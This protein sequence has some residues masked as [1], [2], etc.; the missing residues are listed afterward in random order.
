[1][2]GALAP[3]S[4]STPA[5]RAAVGDREHTRCLGRFSARAGAALAVV[6]ELALVA[7]VAHNAAGGIDLHV[8]R[9]HAAGQFLAAAARHLLVSA[10]HVKRP[11][12]V[13]GERSA[14][15]GGSEA[16]GIHTA[17]LLDESGLV[18]GLESPEGRSGPEGRSASKRRHCQRWLGLR[19][20]LA[21]SV[22]CGAG[23]E[24][25]GAK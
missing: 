9:L 14:G 18:K 25:C 6:L 11:V 7:G 15:G 21:H 12:I 4:G 3:R 16:H 10:V 19:G 5:A 22:G 13:A 8:V 17:E 2:V 23:R 24:G 1:V 20:T